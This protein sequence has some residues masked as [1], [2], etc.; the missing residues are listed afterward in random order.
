MRNL[1]LASSTVYKNQRYI[2]LMGDSPT[3]FYNLEW[4]PLFT[5]KN[6]DMQ[7]KNYVPLVLCTLYKIYSNDQISQILKMLT[8][9]YFLHL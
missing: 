6:Y 2:A 1:S 8:A 7:M 4:C 3:D 5:F 9:L